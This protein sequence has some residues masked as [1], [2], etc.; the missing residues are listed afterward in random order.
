[1][2]A[3]HGE[4]TA[5]PLADGRILIAGGFTRVAE[6][7]DPA[8]DQFTETA[9][10]M[11]LTCAGHTA[12]RLADG[13]VLLTGGFSGSA[14]GGTVVATAELFDPASGSFALTASMTEPRY[15]HAAALLPDGRV[16]VAGGWSGRQVLS[17]AEVYDPGRGSW[18]PIA[19]MQE[20]RMGH[21]LTPRPDGSVLAVG[22]CAEGTTERFDPV[23]DRFLAAGPLAE[24]RQ[25]HTTTLLRGS[26]V[27]IV[28]GYGASALASAEML[29]GS[30]D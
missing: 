8:S 13:R 11:P 4:H 3:P 26:R 16:L 22:G 10:A 9:G 28:G 12:T 1:M 6:I 20:R 14:F 23:T 7:F 24:P 18:T 17:T 19:P 5:T 2:A 25:G 27:L 15:R 21:T 29:G 30:G